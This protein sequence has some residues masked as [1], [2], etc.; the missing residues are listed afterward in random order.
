[1]VRGTLQLEA[2]EMHTFK[3][4]EG[5]FSK[6]C[7]SQEGRCLVSSMRLESEC[8]TIGKSLTFP[9]FTKVSKSWGSFEG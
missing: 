7:D 9:A 8:V 6:S 4:P 3:R 2:Q 1:M 5:G